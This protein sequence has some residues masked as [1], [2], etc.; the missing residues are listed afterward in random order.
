M[1]K[2]GAILGGF[3]EFTN[4]GGQLTAL[5]TAKLAW[6]HVDSVFLPGIIF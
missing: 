3:D 2:H 6:S 4:S 5:Q 1:E